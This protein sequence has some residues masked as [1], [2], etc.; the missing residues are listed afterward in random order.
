M[1][2]L[3]GL[4]AYVFQDKRIKRAKNYRALRFWAK[5][6]HRKVY[7]SLYTYYLRRKEKQRTYYQAL[8]DRERE[9]TK[10]SLFKIIKVGQYWSQRQTSKLYSDPSSQPWSG[11]TRLLTIKK[12]FFRWYCLSKSYE[13]PTT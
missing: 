6:T 8:K 1:K 5:S 13:R 7:F 12:A 2:G 9:I 10:I 4:K 3:E 11:F